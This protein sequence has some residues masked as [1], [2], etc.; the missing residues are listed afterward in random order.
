MYFKP[1]AIILGHVLNDNDIGNFALSCLLQLLMGVN[2]SHV[3]DDSVA[4]LDG[5][6][7]V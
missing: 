3:H 7:A 4:A 5:D 1:V 2:V 6:T